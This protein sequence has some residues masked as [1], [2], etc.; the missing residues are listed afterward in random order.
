M[1]TE[2]ISARISSASISQVKGSVYD[3]TLKIL[4]MQIPKVQSPQGRI[5][6]VNDR[7]GVFTAS[8]CVVFVGLIMKIIIITNNSEVASLR[9]VVTNVSYQ[10]E[11]LE[12]AELIDVLKRVRDAVHKGHQLLTHPLSGSVKPYET[13]YKSVALSSEVGALDMSSLETVENAIQMAET[14][15][16]NVKVER[17]LTDKILTDFRLIDLQLISNALK[18]VK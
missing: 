18:S 11:F 6:Q 12:T 5:S 15:K 7:G 17:Q 14:F 16:R 2:G 10:I 3:G 9:P 13:P 4:L 1:V 8:F